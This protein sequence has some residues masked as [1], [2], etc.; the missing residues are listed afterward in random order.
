MK[1]GHAIICALF[2][3]SCAK[4]KPSEPA[5]PALA[6]EVEA[7]D[8]AADRMLGM[9]D[10]GWIVSRG[11]GGEVQHEGD[12]LLWTGMALGTLDCARAA[13]VSQALLAMIDLEAGGLYRHPSLRGQD[14]SMDGALGFYW[15][16]VKHVIRCP[17]DLE[18]WHVAIASHQAHGF[19]MP[20]KGFEHVQKDVFHF[21]GLLAD[22]GTNHDLAEEGAAWAAAVNARHAAAYRI[23]LVLLAYQLVEATGDHLLGSQRDRFCSATRGTG[24]P[25][26]DFYC[27]RDDL[28]NWIAAY[29]PNAWE[30]RHQRGQWESPDGGGLET[31]GLDYLVALRSVYQLPD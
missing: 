2:L 4:A 30:F 14:V 17:D 24:M 26:T 3:S 27:G 11:S 10:G 20:T 22:G 31:P 29:V 1:N 25:T 16:V 7:Y 8:Q 5:A 6:P 28:T 18:A 13:P 23:H 15:G 19:K 21:F 9:A 12:S